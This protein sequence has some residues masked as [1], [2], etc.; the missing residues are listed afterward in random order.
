MSTGGPEETN[1]QKVIESEHAEFKPL[2]I[3]NIIYNL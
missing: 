2:A 1:S 3:I